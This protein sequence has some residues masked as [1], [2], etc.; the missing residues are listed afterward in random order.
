MKKKVLSDKFFMVKWWF[1][2]ACEGTHLYNINWMNE[3]YSN[4]SCC[5]SHTNL[6]QKTRSWSSCC[7][8]LLFGGRW[9]QTHIVFNFLLEKKVG[10][11]REDLVVFVA[12]RKI[13]TIT[14]GKSIF[15]SNRIWEFCFLALIG[16]IERDCMIHLQSTV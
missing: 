13:M 4:D 2:E 8:D 11:Y 15:R 6:L 14:G 7:H 16:T 5:T 12:Q 10:W 3:R 9:I 1:T